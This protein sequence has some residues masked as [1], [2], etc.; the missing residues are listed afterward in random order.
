MTVGSFVV[1]K[2]EPGCDFVF[3]KTA[4]MGACRCT[5]KD[6]SVESQEITDQSASEMGRV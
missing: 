6:R 1:T 4:L 3:R 5:N 2:G